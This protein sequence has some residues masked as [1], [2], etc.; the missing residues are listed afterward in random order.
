MISMPLSTGRDNPPINGFYEMMMDLTPERRKGTSA[1]SGTAQAG[2]TEDGY[3]DT[4][5]PCFAPSF[6][7]YG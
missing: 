7:Q 5:N 6:G 4:L 2:T 1:G 3:Q